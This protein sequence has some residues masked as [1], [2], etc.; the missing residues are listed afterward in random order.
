MSLAR[1]HRDR[2]LAAQTVLATDPASAPD[3]GA[4]A[5]SAA[6]S[7]PAAGAAQIVLRLTHD[8]RRLKEIKSVDAKISAKREMLPEYGSWVLGLLE[9]DTGVGNGLS[10][11]VLPTIMVWLIDVGN[12]DEALELLP[13]L[14]K[15]RVQMPARYKRDAATVAIEEIADAALK[16]LG[17]GASFP[18][19]VLARVTELTDGLDVHDEVRAKLAKAIGIAG[20]ALA[21][22]LPAEEARAALQGALSALLEA[23]RLNDRAGVKDKIK[24]AEKLLAALDT[25]ATPPA[26]DTAGGPAA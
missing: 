20:L 1:R 17:L 19:E 7:F 15:H 12:Y 6:D 16:A 10:A 13:F 11:E 24:R 9:A 25:A 21:E 2:V 8:L 18:L 26:S 5:A 4:D 22:E 23:Q 14:L 3:G